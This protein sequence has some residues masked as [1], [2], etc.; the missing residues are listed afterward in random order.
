MLDGIFD[1]KA[2]GGTLGD[3]PTPGSTSLRTGAD[4]GDYESRKDLAAATGRKKPL[5]PRFCKNEVEK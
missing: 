2:G 4:S 1:D 5:D 3:L